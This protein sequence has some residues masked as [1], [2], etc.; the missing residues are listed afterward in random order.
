MTL[1]EAMQCGIGERLTPAHNVAPFKLGDEVILAKFNKRK[2]IEDNITTCRVFYP[3]D[4]QLYNTNI[5]DFKV[6]V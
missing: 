2:A 4:G 5:L 1:E 6:K 3:K